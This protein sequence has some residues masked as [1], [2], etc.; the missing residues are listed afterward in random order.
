MG[1]VADAW[2]IWQDQKPQEPP[3]EPVETPKPAPDGSDTDQTEKTRPR[4]ESG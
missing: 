3:Q 1:V 2:Y 4:P